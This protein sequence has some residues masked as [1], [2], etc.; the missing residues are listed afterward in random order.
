MHVQRHLYW[1]H[2]ASTAT[3]TY[4][5]MHPKRGLLAMEAAGILANFTGTAVHDGWPSYWRY[6]LCTHA[7]CNAHH[8]RELIAAEENT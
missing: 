4:Y 6:P 3:L 5:L 8:E 7:L 1:L 2:S